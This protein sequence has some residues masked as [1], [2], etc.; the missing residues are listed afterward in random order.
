MSVF[1]SPYFLFTMVL[2]LAFSVTLALAAETEMA[3]EEY[4]AQLAQYTER[5]AEA[6]KELDNLLRQ[7][8]ATDVEISEAEGQIVEIWQEIYDL[9]GS[10]EAGVR[11]FMD[12]LG[13]IEAEI[14]N[15]QALSPD[16]LY[17]QRKDIDVL[18]Q[19][20]AERK[21]SKIAALPDVAARIV[22]IEGMIDELRGMF[23]KVPPPDWYT[24][25]R[26]DC[27]WNISEKEDI[28]GDPYMWP[29]IYR[30]NR[31]QVKD[32]DLVYPNQIF[33]VPRGVP[34]SHHLVIRGE[35]LA[36]I[37]GYPEWYGD[38]TKWTKIY[39]AN[40]DQIRNPDLIYPA[41]ELLIPEE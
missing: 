33:S 11:A 17:R 30:A 10:D 8:D 41:Q 4:E 2:S 18:E 20:V 6:H 14:Y 38:I 25:V 15:L 24:V 37:A 19:K 12:E 22:R 13:A 7:I 36:K 28:Y 40:K 27:L 32:P 31:D 34:L 26:G 39:Q 9:I 29:R 5:A 3:Y 16:D 21:T 1:K 35:W 23:P